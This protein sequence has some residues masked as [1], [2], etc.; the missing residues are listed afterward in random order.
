MKNKVWRERYI[1]AYPFR[2]FSSKPDGFVAFS[3][4][5]G[6]HIMEESHKECSAPRQ[7]GSKDWSC[8]VGYFQTSD[9]NVDIVS[10]L[11]TSSLKPTN[12]QPNS[13]AYG[14]SIEV[15]DQ[16]RWTMR[17][18]LCFLAQCSCPVYIPSG[19]NLACPHSAE[20]LRWS[21]T[22]KALSKAFFMCTHSVFEGVKLLRRRSVLRPFFPLWPVVHL[23]HC[24][25]YTNQK[26]LVV[27]ASPEE[28]HRD[29]CKGRVRDSTAHPN[30]RQIQ[31][32][33]RVIDKE[34]A[35]R[36]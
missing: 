19:A 13:L 20:S 5:P 8:S 32:A 11:L 21:E 27:T 17:A 25:T 22:E 3:S 14:L 28:D 34:V 24:P 29:C 23:C 7:Q 12:W 10:H 31:A 16:T 6:R 33:L 18:Q 4:V 26:W 9:E 35:D 1:L 15:S 30:R 2:V 36:E